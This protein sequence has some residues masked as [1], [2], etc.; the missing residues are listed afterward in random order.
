MKIGLITDSLQHLSFDALL[1][2]AAEMGIEALEI[3][4]ANW[5]SAKHIDL[6]GMLDGDK[7]RREYA[8]KIKDHGLEISALN[9][10]GN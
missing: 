1:P 9:C 6:D 10:S 2:I 4:C 3:G 8:A 7:A 5:S